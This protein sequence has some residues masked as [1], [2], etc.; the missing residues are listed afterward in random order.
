MKFLKRLN[1]KQLDAII[2]NIDI[3]GLD[4]EMILENTHEAQEAVKQL[5][6]N[7]IELDNFKYGLKGENI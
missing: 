2:Q 6:P 3:I 4:G 1:K 7:L 5:Y